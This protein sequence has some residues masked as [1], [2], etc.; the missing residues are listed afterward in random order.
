MELEELRVW[1]AAQR[2][3][4]QADREQASARTPKPGQPTCQGLIHHDSD[5][6]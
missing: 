4:G 2:E 6:G 3:G 1:G 5:E